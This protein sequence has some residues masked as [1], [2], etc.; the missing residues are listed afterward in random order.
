MIEKAPYSL[1]K[2]IRSVS[3]SVLIIFLI[4]YFYFLELTRNW[5]ALQNYKLNINFYCLAVSLLLCVLSGLMDTNVWKIC[6][7]KHLGKHALTFPESISIANTSGLL[8]YVPGKIWIYTAQLAW[9]KKYGISKTKILHSNFICT[10]A[11]MTVSIYL[12]LVYIAL[13]TRHLTTNL[14][15]LFSIVLILLNVAYIAF[16]SILLN[17]LITTANKFLKLDIPLLTNS[18]ALLVYIQFMYAFSWLLTGLAGYYLVIGVGL[19]IETS[20]LFALLASMSLSWLVGYL[21][22]ITPNGLGVRE[23]F[24]LLMLNQVVNVQTALL[25][26][27]FSRIMFLLAEALLGLLALLMGIKLKVF[28]SERCK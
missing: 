25:F 19:Q 28:A 4:G 7:N 12:G 13:Y 16:N 22:V 17:K 3:V 10:I 23:G 20:E 24:M 21:A 8:R 15:I 2:K 6:I 9:L 1:K 26:P 14:I 18:I 11:S 5:A 27:I